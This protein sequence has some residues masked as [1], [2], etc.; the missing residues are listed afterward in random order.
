VTANNVGTSG[1]VPNQTGSSAGEGINIAQES[2]GTTTIDV[3]NNHVF[4]IK[5]GWG[6][7][8]QVGNGNGTLNMTVTGNTVDTQSTASLDGINLNSG[9]LPGDVSVVCLNATGNT[10]TSEGTSANP[11]AG[12]G[13]FDAA[14]LAVIQNTPSAIF[15]IQGYPGSATDDT[16]V[17][18]FLGTHP[19]APNNVLSGPPGAEAAACPP[20]EPMRLPA[21]RGSPP[22]RARSRRR[23]VRA[24]TSRAAARAGS[25]RPP[26]AR[27]SATAA[28]PARR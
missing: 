23:S 9:I 24:G 8:G 22:P 3:S 20:R 4:G 13:L 12:N 18:T 21:A 19:A 6:I 5:G 17:A 1:S 16:A 27:Q 7:N 28:P 25:G 2:T 15:R 26:R 11:P 10:S 14:G